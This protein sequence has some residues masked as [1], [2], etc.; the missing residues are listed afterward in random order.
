MLPA[1]TDTCTPAG[2][3]AWTGDL[4][5]RGVSLWKARLISDTSSDRLDTP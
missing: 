3:G 2:G 5:Y 4:A 1:N